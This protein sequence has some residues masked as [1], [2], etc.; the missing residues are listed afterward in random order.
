MT[1]L[2]IP[3]APS[4]QNLIEQNVKDSISARIPVYKPD[5]SHLKLGSEKENEIIEAAQF[6]SQ[7][8][9]QARDNRFAQKVLINDNTLAEARKIV[10]DFIQKAQILHDQAV[11]KINEKYARID[12]LHKD[13]DGLLHSKKIRSAMEDLK[14]ATKEIRDRIDEIEGGIYLADSYESDNI[15]FFAMEAVKRLHDGK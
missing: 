2:N 6:I 5:A 3:N 1:K 4:L 8:E 10:I 7:R 9:T 15:T 11:E 14:N 12:K 13:I